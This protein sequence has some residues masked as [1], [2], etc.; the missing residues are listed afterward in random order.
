LSAD[1]V[2]WGWEKVSGKAPGKTDEEKVSGT[3][4]TVEIV[5]QVAIMV[6]GRYHSFASSLDGS[7]VEEKVSGTAL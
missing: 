5:S 4:G 7:G 6:N 2:S 3:N 1:S